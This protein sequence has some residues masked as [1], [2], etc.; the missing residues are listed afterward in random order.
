MESAPSIG[1]ASYYLTIL[2]E[3]RYR[4]S[5]HDAA[6]RLQ[7]AAAGES[8]DGLRELV[9][10]QVEAVG[11]AAARLAGRRGQREAVT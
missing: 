9:C 1:S 3:H 6:T 2:V 11:A 4:R 8:L 10:G 7:Q 5:V